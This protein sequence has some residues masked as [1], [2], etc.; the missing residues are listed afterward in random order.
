MKAHSIGE[1]IY[2]RTFDDSDIKDNIAATK[3]V[4]LKHIIWILLLIIIILV[5]N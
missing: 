2:C 4:D 5:E 1:G 3:K